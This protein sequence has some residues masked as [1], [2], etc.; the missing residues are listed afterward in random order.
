MKKRSKQIAVIACMCAFG[1]M[2]L[3][4]TESEVSTGN[5]DTEAVESTDTDDAEQ[6]EDTTEAAKGDVTLKVGEYFENDGLKI[7]VL[8]YNSDFTEY[9]EWSKPSDGMKY[10]AVSFNYTNNAAEGTKYVSIYDYNCYADDVSVNQA[11]LGSDNFTNDN[12]APGRSRSFTTYYE[13]PTDA[14][15]IELEYTETFSFD[16]TRI[17]IVLQ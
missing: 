13:V 10:I 14:K 3:G 6:K 12:I 11:Y 16:N 4:S 2:A 5:V 1:I 17:V 9:D 8:D 15:S 7:E